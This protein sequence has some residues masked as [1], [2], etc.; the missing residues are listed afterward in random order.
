MTIFNY[1]PPN[2]TLI[3]FLN[4]LF[5]DRSKLGIQGSR[6]LNDFIISKWDITA[7]EWDQWCKM[8]SLLASQINPHTERND[9]NLK[10]MFRF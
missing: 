7:S 6:K 10:K 5:L 9:W 1:I 2:Y 3:L 8:G 4:L